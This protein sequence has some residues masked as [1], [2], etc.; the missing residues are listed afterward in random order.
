M[1]VVGSGTIGGPSTDDQETQGGAPSDEPEFAEGTVAR[2]SDSTFV[3]TEPYELPA[4]VW[5]MERGGEQVSRVPYDG[6]SFR[7]PLSDQPM[8]LAVV[9]EFDRTTLP[10]MMLWDGV[11]QEPRPTLAPDQ[12][13]A[14]ILGG[15][16]YADTLNELRAHLLVQ[17]VAADDRVGGVAGVKPLVPGGPTLAFE[18]RGVWSDIDEGTGESG[19]FLSY[20][21][22]ARALPGQDVNV[23][24][25]GTVDAEF[26]VRLAEGVLTM[27]TYEVP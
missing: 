6:L 16:I 22:V 21:I 25:T 4:Q 3:L 12:M 20:N 19:L 26:Q 2:F 15:L 23:T 10:T 14:E 1:G 27:V 5:L 24:L 11:D 9:P 8:W 17:V 18:E 7:A 13:L